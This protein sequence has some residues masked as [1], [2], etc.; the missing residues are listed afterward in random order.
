MKDLTHQKFNV[1]YIW[2][3]LGMALLGGFPIGTYV[4]FKLNSSGKSF[5]VIP[6]L[7][8]IHGHV[9]LIGWVGLFVMGV[10][11][12]F[13]P[14]FI[15]VPLRRPRF[16]TFILQCIVGGLSLQVGARFLH[17]PS[18][19][20]VGSLAEWVGIAT[21]VFILVELY[22]SKIS[23][24]HE[25]TLKL[26]PYFLMAF[27]GWIIFST[28]HLWLTFMAVRQ[29]ALMIPIVWQQWNAEFFMAF[30]LFP[31][32]YAFS[33]RTF[34]LFLQL[35][36]TIK[37]PVHIWGIIY[38]TVTL[39]A[40][41]FWLPPLLVAFPEFS[42]KAACVGRIGRDLFILW[43]VWAL[44]LFFRREP[45]PW[46][47]LAVESPNPPR[48]GLADA[49]EYG[50]FEWAIRSAY[51]W[52]TISVGLDLLGALSGMFGWSLGIGPDPIRHAFLLGFITL[53]II[54]M[55]SRMVPGFMLKKRIAHPA[56]VGW[57][58]VFG[59]AAVFLRVIPGVIP[60]KWVQP[61]PKTADLLSQFM[62]LAGIVGMVSIAI[63]ALNLGMTYRLQEL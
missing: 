37:K 13:F 4:L 45:S 61:W 29:G 60:E 36:I 59:N 8:Q 30:V 27:A 21:Y 32:A 55:A 31:V 9:Q 7:I 25:S 47:P 20:L 14:R 62:P 50:R 11:L 34:P 12:F 57:G 46:V 10:S 16:L 35:P 42:L 52:L 19:A 44:Q 48:K 54:G 49:G 51:L 28:Q 18:L 22:F 26:K 23:E 63:L 24:P 43:M 15:G 33:I 2:T 53:L 58:T 40:K 41:V 38:L 1:S 17:L 39:F 6:D 56:L 3:S 5:G